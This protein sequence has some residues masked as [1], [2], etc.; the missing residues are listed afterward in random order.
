MTDHEE[1]KRIDY[2]RRSKVE[3]TLQRL[4]REKPMRI[5]DYLILAGG[6]V[7]IVA[8]PLIFLS[9]FF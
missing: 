7:A 5:R 4:G 1:Q 9:F 8:I 3:A 6:A 2:A